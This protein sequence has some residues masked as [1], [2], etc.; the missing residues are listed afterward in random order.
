[1]N[2]DY[3]RGYRDARLDMICKFGRERTAIR[4]AALEEAASAMVGTRED[5]LEHSNEY[6]RGVH[7]KEAAI[8]ALKEGK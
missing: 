4:N 8:R 6:R 3:R 5:F 2:D 1:M 7:E